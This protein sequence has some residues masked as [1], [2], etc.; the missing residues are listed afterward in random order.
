MAQTAPEGMKRS[1]AAGFVLTR[2]PPPGVPH[3]GE[4]QYLILDNRRDGMP[5]LPKGHADEGEDDLQTAM[6]ET[7]EETGLTDLQVDPW[8]RVEISYRVRKGGEMR[9]KTVVYFR[10]RARSGEVRLSDEHTGFAWMPLCE[11]LDRFTFESLRDVV[12]QAALHAKDPGL[13]RRFPPDVAAADR[14]LASL[15]HADAGLLSHLRGAARLARA[16]ADALAVAGVPVHPAAA[17]EGALLHDAGRAL[18]RHDD[19]QVVGLSH[20]R[21]TRFAP[22]GF[23]CVSHFAKGARPPDLAAAGVSPATVDAFHRAIDLSTLTWEERCV[24]LADSCMKGGTAVPPAE[25]FADLRRRYDA[26]ALIALQET[27][28]AEIRADLAK[29]LGKDPLSLVGLS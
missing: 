21:T 22:Y 20:L 15:P 25:R 14:H 24:A 29:A 17:E 16:F 4:P 7:E 8:F 1:R 6:R 11:A 5:G 19:H 3:S 12:M 10:A 2:D 13:F 18:G 26:P 28:T 27:R 9:W 23:A